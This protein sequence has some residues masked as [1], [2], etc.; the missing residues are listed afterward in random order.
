MINS[1][2]G[3]TL[4]V[5]SVSIAKQQRLFLR[6]DTRPT[7]DSSKQS[8]NSWKTSFCYLKFISHWFRKISLDISNQFIFPRY[9]C[10][11]GIC[12]M[13]HLNTVIS[14]M[15]L[16]N[17]AFKHI[18]IFLLILKTLIEIFNGIET[19]LPIFRSTFWTKKK[20]KC[21]RVEAPHK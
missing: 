16:L 11:Y 4:S 13:D 20:N 1:T 19:L 15:K 5:W 3:Q 2:F 21:Y 6:S 17:L 12:I 7:K 10:G 8:I 9:L 14:L 18:F